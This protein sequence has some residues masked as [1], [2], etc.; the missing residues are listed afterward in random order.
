LIAYSYIHQPELHN[1]PL[2]LPG[3]HR[4]TY[5]QSFWELRT[6]RPEKALVL[7][8]RILFARIRF[9]ALVETASS[10]AL[11]LD[12]GLREN[13]GNTQFYTLRFSLDALTERQAEA[14]RNTVSHWRGHQQ[15]LARAK[16]Q[17]AVWVYFLGTKDQTDQATFLVADPRL[18]CFFE[19]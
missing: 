19:R 2:Q 10:V 4:S 1:E 14:V 11:T 16:S 8:D 15:E 9:N 17:N 13:H 12:A 5:R 3:R 7:S 18:F 6:S